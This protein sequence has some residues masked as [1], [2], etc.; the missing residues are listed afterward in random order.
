MGSVSIGIQATQGW[1]TRKK[2]CRL[3]VDVYIP[4]IADEKKTFAVAEKGKKMKTTIKKIIGFTAWV[5]AAALQILLYPRFPQMTEVFDILAAVLVA[6]PMVQ[7]II[8]FCK[9]DRSNR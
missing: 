8:L 4:D 3:L 7:V 2:I 6:V 1:E 9:W 5:V